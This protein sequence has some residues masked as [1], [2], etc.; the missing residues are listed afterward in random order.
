MNILLSPSDFS[1]VNSAD[2]Q[3]MLSRL[4]GNLSGFAYRRRHDAGYEVHRFIA[5]ASLAYGDLIVPADRPR[6]EERVRLAVRLRQRAT[7]EY[8]IRTAHGA[9]A[10]VEDRFSPVVNAAGEVIA[11]EGIIDRVR[12]HGPGG[13]LHSRTAN[14]APLIAYDLQTDPS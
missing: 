10:L 5:N 11:I 4:I 12:H 3:A 6:V 13:W 8:R 14:C 9:W 1:I 7:V 2:C